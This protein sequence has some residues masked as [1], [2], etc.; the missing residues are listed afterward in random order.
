MLLLLLML[1]EKTR[2]MTFPTWAVRSVKMKVDSDA[3]GVVCIKIAWDLGTRKAAA[4]RPSQ[5][6]GLP[7]RAVLVGKRT[8][9]ARSRTYNH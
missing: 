9:R 3:I 5:V 8:A 6:F 1:L 7:T 4:R 2:F